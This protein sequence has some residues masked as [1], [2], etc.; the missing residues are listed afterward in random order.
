MKAKLSI[1]LYF[2]LSFSSQGWRS[3]DSCAGAKRKRQAAGHLNESRLRP[4]F[5]E[6]PPELQGNPGAKKN[7]FYVLGLNSHRFQKLFLSEHAKQHLFRS[8]TKT[9]NCFI[10]GPLAAISIHIEVWKHRCANHYSD[11]CTRPF[12]RAKGWFLAV[13][14][15]QPKLWTFCKMAGHVAVDHFSVNMSWSKCQFFWSWGVHGWKT[16]NWR[17]EVRHP[18]LPSFSWR[19]QCQWPLSDPHWAGAKSMEP[20]GKL[21]RPTPTKR[22]F[23]HQK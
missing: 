16:A 12:G 13:L 7:V 2:E 20:E 4:F 5:N 18:R 6:I 21:S 15:R 22:S 1:F 23:K 14:F 19:G 17:F 3:S 9:S 11:L 8:W 10:S